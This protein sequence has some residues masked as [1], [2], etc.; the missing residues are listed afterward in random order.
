[1][2][3]VEDYGGSKFAVYEHDTGRGVIIVD[4]RQGNNAAIFDSVTQAEEKALAL[5]WGGSVQ[6]THRLRKPQT[7]KAGA[8]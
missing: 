4:K 1:M 3:L 2:K 8:Q 6:L 7:A 5:M